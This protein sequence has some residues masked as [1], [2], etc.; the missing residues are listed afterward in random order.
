MIYEVGS[1][2][3]TMYSATQMYQVK[4]GII[5]TGLVKLRHLIVENTSGFENVNG[6][7][8]STKSAF[9]FW[10]LAYFLCDSYI[11]VCIPCGDITDGQIVP[12]VK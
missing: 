3:Y 2:Q 1:V 5:E 6:V 7:T 12:E 9:I 4:S 11:S 10:L 8:A